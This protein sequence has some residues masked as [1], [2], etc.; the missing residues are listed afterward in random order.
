M[1]RN[2]FCNRPVIRITNTKTKHERVWTF[3]DLIETYGD[4]LNDNDLETA[5]RRAGLKFILQLRQIFGVHKDKT[6]VRQ[7]STQQS[8]D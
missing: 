1:F 5:Y 6:E 7:R 4:S 8:Q 2:Q 3:I